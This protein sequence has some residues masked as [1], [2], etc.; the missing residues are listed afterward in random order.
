MSVRGRMVLVPRLLVMALGR[1]VILPQAS[2]AVEHAIT[3]RVPALAVQLRPRGLIRIT[4][5][6][7]HG[8]DAPVPV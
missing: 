2:R 6:P 4:L 5:V 8:T 7:L 3:A 1:V